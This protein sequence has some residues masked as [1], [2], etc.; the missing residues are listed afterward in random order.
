[1]TIFVLSFWVSKIWQFLWKVVYW[2]KNFVVNIFQRARYSL[3][4]KSL[5]MMD[6]FKGIYM[7]SPYHPS[8]LCSKNRFLAK[9][10]KTKTFFTNFFLGNMQD[11]PVVSRY[12]VEH[13]Q[14]LILPKTIQISDF[15][16]ACISNVSLC[17][18][19]SVRPDSGVPNV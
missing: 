19:K 16:L 7:F 2:T 5:I 3:Y 10:K 18:V 15:W 1:M 6:C 4:V 8:F 14:C 13:I 17:N 12:V 11:R 9:M